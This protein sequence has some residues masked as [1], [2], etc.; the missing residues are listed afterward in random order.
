M[1]V[2]S[3]TNSLREAQERLLTPYKEQGEEL[4]PEQEDLNEE[5]H[6][7][8]D[9]FNKGSETEEVEES[10]DDEQ[11]V[12]G[13]DEDDSAPD[14]EESTDET[15]H[16]VKVDGEEYEVNLDELKKGYQLEKN[17]TKKAQALAEEKKEIAVLKAQ[18]AEQ[19]NQ[20]LQI[21]KNLMAEQSADLNNAKQHLSQINR[22][23][24]PI[25]FVQKQLEVQEL[26]GK[27]RHRMSSVQH[28]STE[29]QQQSQEQMQKYLAQ[30][31]DLLK[32]QL[33]GWSDV[34]KSKVIQTSIAKFAE[35]QGYSPEEISGLSNAR[36]VIVLN[37]ARL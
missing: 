3:N 35:A 5:T 1:G 19:R 34:D 32:S 13:D 22:S 4:L 15:F 23:D 6:E 10:T 11:E 28:A 36:D 21:T 33:D 30:Q 18:V 25:G 24:D 37:K 17:Y 27:L 20:Y 29:Q 2:Y 31:N 7:A 9:S 16:T 14:D 12:G 8:E 26:E